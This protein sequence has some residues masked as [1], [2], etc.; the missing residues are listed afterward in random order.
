MTR[1]EP[2]D[3]E[4]VVVGAGPAG[5]AASVSA[6]EA[7]AKV[8]LVDRGPRAG[9]QV[10]RHHASAPSAARPWIR[11]LEGTGVST[12][13]EATV[14]DAPEPGRLVIE[15]S[16]RGRGVRYRHLVLATGA[17][18]RFLPF[19]GW[20]RPGVIGVG[21]AQALLKQG[22]SFAGLRVVVAGTGPL[23]L[24]VAA[25]VAGDGARVV[26]IAEQAPLGRLARF[27]LML[28][29]HPRKVVQGVGCGAR[30]A[31]VPYRT[32]RWIR[33][34]EGGERIERALLTD[35]RREWSWECDVVACAYG[36]VPNLELARLLGCEL[37]GEALALDEAQRTTVP[38]VFGAG[39][40]GGIGGDEHA[41]VT[42]AIAGLGAAGQPIPVAGGPLVLKR[43]AAPVGLALD[44]AAAYVG[45][46]AVRT[47]RCWPLR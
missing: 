8:L 27:V 21:G 32:G 36:L 13:F 47:C 14:V 34:V 16:G 35:G 3:A 20:T 2:L 31:T 44:D 23:L 26:G 18:E 42:G 37:D 29:R 9:G 7:G 22:A 43:G 4:V 28:V 5:L 46:Y 38:G 25:A 41:L 1:A 12:V 24:T 10:W 33:A 30:L 19:P 11:R 39:E 15:Q 17:R 40:L 6:A 45:D